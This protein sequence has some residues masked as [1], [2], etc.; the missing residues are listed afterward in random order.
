[1]SEKFELRRSDKQMSPML[2]SIMKSDE[3]LSSPQGNDNNSSLVPGLFMGYWPSIGCPAAGPALASKYS[4]V[5]GC[6]VICTFEHLNALVRIAYGAVFGGDDETVMGGFELFSLEC[7]HESLEV[8]AVL[9]RSWTL[10]PR[11]VFQ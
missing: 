10:F 3:G 11:F 1:M 8:G 9:R 7:R 2:K 5:F 6:G 4:H